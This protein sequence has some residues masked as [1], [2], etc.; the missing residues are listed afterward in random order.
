[1]SRGV[2]GRE[3]TKPDDVDLSAGPIIQSMQLSIAE[4]KK[5]VSKV[6]TSIRFEQLLNGSGDGDGDGDGDGIHDDGDGDDGDGIHNDGDGDDGDG[7]HD[8]GDDS[9][10]NGSG[11]HND[12]SHNDTT[13]NNTPSHSRSSPSQRDRSRSRHHAHTHHDHSPSHS[14]SRPDRSR[15]RN[16][17]SHS[18]RHHSPSRHHRSPSPD[19][20]YRYGVEDAHNE[21]WLREGLEVKVMNQKLGDGALY[22]KKGVVT[23]LIDP[24]TAKVRIP[25]CNLSIKIDQVEMREEGEE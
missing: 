14:H 25:E 22:K 10:N 24:F 5:E 18:H 12:S 8:D 4:P 3:Y 16:D 7:I 1:M 23:G 2:H 20:T 13:H 11:S 21:T 17:H 15:S 19:D 6:D 9:H